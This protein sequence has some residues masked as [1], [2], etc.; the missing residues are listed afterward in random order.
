MEWAPSDKMTITDLRAV[1]TSWD[2]PTLSSEKSVLIREVATHYH[3]IMLAWMSRR[4]AVPSFVSGLPSYAP[5]VARSSGGDDNSIGTDCPRTELND[6]GS[7]VAAVD[8]QLITN[9]IIWFSNINDAAACA[10]APE[11]DVDSGEYEV[12]AAGNTLGRKETKELGDDERD[13]LE[14]EQSVA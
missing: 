1:L 2:I 12:D 5:G 9:N 13:E 10:A 11:E 3:E 8:T 14:Y 4:P 7:E 6:I